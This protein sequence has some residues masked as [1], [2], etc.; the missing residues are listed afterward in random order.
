MKLLSNEPNTLNTQMKACTLWQ[1][2]TP[3]YMDDVGLADAV[4]TP[5]KFNVVE[6]NSVK[7]VNINR[8]FDDPEYPDDS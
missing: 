2:D 3:G 8:A 6:E 7:K 5:V 4:F 1:K